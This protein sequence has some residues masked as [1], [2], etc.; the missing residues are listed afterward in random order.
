[1]NSDI[2]NIIDTIINDDIININTIRQEIIKNIN[3]FIKINKKLYNKERY[4]TED[5][6]DAIVCVKIIDNTNNKPIELLSNNILEHYNKNI[7]I[8]TYTINKIMRQLSNQV[9]KKITT[10]DFDKMSKE[11]LIDFIKNNM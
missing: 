1:M 10:I 4:T 3:Y 2:K 7:N 9:C 6:I 5:I 8:F 11:E